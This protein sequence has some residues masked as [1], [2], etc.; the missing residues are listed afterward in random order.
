MPDVYSSCEHEP[1]VDAVGDS[2]RDEGER[3]QPARQRAPSGRDE[4]SERDDAEQHQV[5]HRVAEPDERRQVGCDGHVPQD[6]PPPDQRE[7]G[8]RKR[9]VEHRV[10]PGM[11]ERRPEEDHERDEREAVEAE[12]ARVGPPRERHR[13]GAELAHTPEHLTRQPGGA[14]ETDQDPV[15][16]QTSAEPVTQPKRR[17]T[18]RPQS[19]PRKPCRRRPVG[20][21]PRPGQ[22]RARPRRTRARRRRRRERRPP[23]AVR[24]WKP[25]IR[26]RAPPDLLRPPYGGSLLTLGE[27]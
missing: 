14:G 13:A 3:D 23:H 4:R 15:A 1:C 22:A 24:E 12:V 6:E 27:L 11:P 19:A 18:W 20:L 2:T 26:H 25:R 8:D 9:T 16:T 10:A 7:R 21:G 17:A 5:E